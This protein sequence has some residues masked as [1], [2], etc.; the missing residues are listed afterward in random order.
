M[1]Q[2]PRGKPRICLTATTRRTR[3]PLGAGIVFVCLHLLERC[4]FQVTGWSA[5]VDYRPRVAELLRH[6]LRTALLW[7]CV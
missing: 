4:A 2:V 6:A 5:K 3:P 7:W 1:N